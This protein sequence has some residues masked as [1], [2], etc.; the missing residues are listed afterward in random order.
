MWHDWNLKF[1][2]KKLLGIFGLEAVNLYIVIATCNIPI[3]VMII[4]IIIIYFCEKYIFYLGAKSSMD[5]SFVYRTFLFLFLSIIK[6]RTL[7][8]KM[9]EGYYIFW[10][11]KN[12]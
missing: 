12:W 6:K 3:M 11:N 5:V 9:L 10:F 8:N 7:K 4:I 2:L 1:I